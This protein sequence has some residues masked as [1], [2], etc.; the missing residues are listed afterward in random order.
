MPG[1]NGTGPMGGGP[2]T[3][4]GLGYC[5]P[6]GSQM[7]PVAG[8]GMGM[9]F[10]RGLGGGMGRGFGRNA[11]YSPY[12][13]MPVNQ[14][15]SADELTMLRSEAEAIKQNMESINARIKELESNS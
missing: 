7:R 9:G 12:Y 15:N 2:M 14:M 13:N 10:R 11:N 1:F 3:G 8:R 5:N 4:R 6:T